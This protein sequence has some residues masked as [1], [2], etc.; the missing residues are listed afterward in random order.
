[1]SVNKV[2]LL[3]RLGRDP[4]VRHTAGGMAIANLRIATNERRRDG[5]GG[6]QDATEWHTVV[7]FDKK[8]ELARQYLTKGRE[9]FVEG[10]LR[11]RQ[12]Q[13]QQGQKRQNTEIIAS[14]IRFVGGRPGAGAGAG[15]ADRGDE[16]GSTVPA[17]DS[18]A[19]D[20]GGGPDDDIPF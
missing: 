6:W 4:E 7:L 17:D 2:M 8:A 15:G 3:G 14:D 19:N 11:T 9:V 1:M 5:N 10:S 13:D 18:M 12:W 16:M 20:F